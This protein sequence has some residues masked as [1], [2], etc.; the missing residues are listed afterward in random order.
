LGTPVLFDGIQPAADLM[1][2]KGARRIDAGGVKV[3]VQRLAEALTSFAQ[4]G[5]LADLRNHIRSRAVP[6]W[7][8]FAQH[9]CQAMNSLHEDSTLS[10]PRG[11]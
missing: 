11:G 9:V 7:G 1:V 6:S 3:D 8:D 5:A 4:P 2:G 10:I